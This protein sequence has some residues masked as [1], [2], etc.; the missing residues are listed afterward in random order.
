MSI[1]CAYCVHLVQSEALSICG[2]SWQALNDSHLV[3]MKQ[4]VMK[5]G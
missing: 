5:G 2:E 1:L 4:V 3:D